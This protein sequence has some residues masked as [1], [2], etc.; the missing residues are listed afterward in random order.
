[1]CWLLTLL[2]IWQLAR[3]HASWAINLLTLLLRKG[4][5]SMRSR[6]TWLR[7][8]ARPTLLWSRIQK[9]LYTTAIQAVPE[10]K[11]SAKAPDSREARK[12]ALPK[13]MAATAHDLLREPLKLLGQWHCF[14]CGHT[15]AHKHLREWLMDVPC[16]PLLH[17]AVP[18]LC[19][20]GQPVLIGLQ[21][22]HGSH[23]KRGIWWCVACGSWASSAARNLSRPCTG[24][25]TKA[26]Q[27]ALA[28]L[29]KGITLQTSRPVAVSAPLMVPLCGL[30][31]GDPLGNPGRRPKNHAEVVAVLL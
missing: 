31:C 25:P 28:R 23:N 29:N 3:G 18:D 4:P 21:A 11:G 16:V 27:D 22:T 14:R 2:L 20:A 26:A 30:G 8:S 17:T 19:H 7:P 9:Q 10:L 12:L 24:Q 1:M 5:F 6:W 13:L 15:I